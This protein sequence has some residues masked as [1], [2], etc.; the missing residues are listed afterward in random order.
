MSKPTMTRENGCPLANDQ[1]ST[2]AGERGPLTFDNLQ[3]F[4]NSHTFIAN[5][6]QSVWCMPVVLVPMVLSPSPT[7]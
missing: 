2:T 5:E 3:L 7:H 4:E 6:F 1:V